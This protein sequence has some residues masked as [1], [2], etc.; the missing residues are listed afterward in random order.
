VV[1]NKDV[2]PLPLAKGER[3]ELIFV[4]RTPMP[5]PMHSARPRISGR[6][7]RRQ[8]LRRAVRDT[9]LVPPGRRVVVAFDAD[10]P[11]FG[12]STVTCSTISKPG[13]SRP[14]ATCDLW[15][16]LKQRAWRA[17]AIRWRYQC[18]LMIV[19]E[20]VRIE[21]VRGCGNQV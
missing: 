14:C 1:W 6:R 20:I 17:A 5:H 12:P 7:D 15:A 19:S 13:C 18:V 3:V 21:C 10:N 8:A 9:V 11:D 2:A 16:A 4:N